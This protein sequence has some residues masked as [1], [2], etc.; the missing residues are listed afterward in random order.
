MN[1]TD[2]ELGLGTALRAYADTTSTDL[3]SL[4]TSSRRAGTRIRRRR[5]IAV[6][7]GTTAAV[8]GI[9]GVASLGAAL[10]GGTTTTQEGL[11]FAAQPTAAP[12]T[13]KAHHRL[14]SL[15]AGR[16]DAIYHG[17]AVTIHLAGWKQVGPVADDKQ[18]LEGPGGAVAGIVWREGAEHDAWASSADKGNASGVW[19]SK[20][21]HGVFV[22]IQAG[23]GTSDADVQALGASL[24]WN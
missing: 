21:H 6:T 1:D 3:D 12:H 18:T 17:Q 11:G 24:T 2:L 13:P 22:S 14:R 20:V 8:A 19:T 15:G 16:T 4:V 23:S 9:V 7:V 10:S 5:R